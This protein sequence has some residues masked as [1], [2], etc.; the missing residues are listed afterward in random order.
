[1]KNM[2]KKIILLFAGL[3]GG[4][5]GYVPTLFGA[6]SFG[7]WSILGSLVGGLVGI[8]LGVQFQD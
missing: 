5:G 1:M 8:Y 2:D 7:G 6:S 4:I 3:G